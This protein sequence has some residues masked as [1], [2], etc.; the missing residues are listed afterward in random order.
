MRVL[1]FLGVIFI[2][3]GVFILWRRPTYPTRHDVVKIGD[4]KATVDQEEAVPVWLGAAA[5]G[6][7]AVLLF[8][9]SRRR[10]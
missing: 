10:W 6:A 9:A 2:L 3:A 1:Q 4:F 8:A 5:V 7:G